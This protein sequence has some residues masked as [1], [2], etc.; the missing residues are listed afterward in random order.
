MS[1]D[2]MSAMR[3]DFASHCD[4]GNLNTPNAPSPKENKKIYELL[5]MLGSEF[6]IED[7]LITLKGGD[8]ISRA[9]IKI[10]TKK[11]NYSPSFRANKEYFAKE[12]SVDIEFIS[13]DYKLVIRLNNQWKHNLEGLFSEEEVVKIIADVEAKEKEHKA[14]LERE[15]VYAENKLAE[16][17]RYVES[18]KAKLVNL[19]KGEGA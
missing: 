1:K 14:N 11:Y 18:C 15:R 12:K 5:Q 7:N 9:G 6:K 2:I 3:R 8:L 4:W 13:Y 10:L 16:A 17:E 19:S